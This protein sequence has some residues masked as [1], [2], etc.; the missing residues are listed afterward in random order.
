MIVIDDSTGSDVLDYG[1]KGL[2]PRD[3]CAQPLRAVDMPVISRDRWPE[4][5]KRQ[6]AAKRRLSDVRRRGNFGSPIPSLNQGQSNYCW[7]HGITHLAMLIRAQMGLPYVPLS[8]FAVCATIKGGANEGGWGALAQQFATERGIPAQ[9]FWAQGDR[10]TRRSRPGCWE[11][12][13]LHKVGEQWADM[14]ADV[15]DRDL[16][17]DQV[18][19]CLLLGVPVGGDFNWWGHHVC[20]LDLVEVDSSLPLSS[21]DRWAIDLWNSWGDE[22]GEQGIGRIKGRKAVPDNATAICTMTPSVE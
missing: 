20:L 19:T 2:L 14:A 15:W 12:A 4:L 1:A 13:S 3:Y 6:A 8:A 18:G 7:G 11:N 5:I 21:P 17:F 22:W 16:S 9:S 10:D